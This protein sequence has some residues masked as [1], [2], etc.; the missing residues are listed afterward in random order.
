MSTFLPSRT[1]RFRATAAAAEALDTHLQTAIAELQP[2]SPKEV[3]PMRGLE[4]LTSLAQN[5]LD[6]IDKQAGD[7]ADRIIAAKE[8]AASAVEGFANLAVSMEDKA[9]LVEQALAQLTNSP[10]QASEPPKTPVPPLT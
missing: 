4:R 9:R 7:A 2:S 10:P 5:A 8:R 1:G 3:K 6:D